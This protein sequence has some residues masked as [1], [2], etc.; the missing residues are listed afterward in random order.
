MASPASLPGSQGY[1]HSNTGE[2]PGE[3]ALSAL[4][5]IL[6]LASLVVMVYIGKKTLE[7]MRS[8]QGNG[9]VGPG[10][11][12]RGPAPRADEV[13]VDSSN[14]ESNPESSTLHQIHHVL[15]GLQVIT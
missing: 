5:V 2:F 8:T 14:A 13:P 11:V 9:E 12:E 1:D 15:V 10:G 6:T 4:S 7:I 3:I